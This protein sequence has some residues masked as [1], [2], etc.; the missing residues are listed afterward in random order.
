MTKEIFRIHP[1]RIFFHWFGVFV[2]F[3]I[4]A[5]AVILLLWLPYRS[6]SLKACPS[7]CRYD[8][9]CWKGCGSKQTECFKIA[10]DPNGLGKCK[11]A[12]G[13]KNLLGLAL[14]FCFAVLGGLWAIIAIFQSRSRIEIDEKGLYYRMIRKEIHIPWKELMG[15]T[16]HCVNTRL[17]REATVYSILGDEGLFSFI[18]PG[19]PEDSMTRELEG[20]ALWFLPLSRRQAKRILTL[21]KEHT[22]L[23]PEPEQEW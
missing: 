23:T 9:D 16:Y 10:N 14:S 3:A 15:V 4:A 5:L 7:F 12:S 1:A 18:S 22:D 20:G 19:I 8:I 21:I 6:V 17:G 11:L 2:S 13:H